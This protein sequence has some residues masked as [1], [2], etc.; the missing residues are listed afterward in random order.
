MYGY[1]DNERN[2]TNK[3]L[4]R[5]KHI[6]KKEKYMEKTDKILMFISLIIIIYTIGFIMWMDSMQ[7]V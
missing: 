1:E 4:Y 6:L 7:F 3:T 5:I 2:H